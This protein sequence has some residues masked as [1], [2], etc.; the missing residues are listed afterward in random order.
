MLSLQLP[1]LKQLWQITDTAVIDAYRSHPAGPQ[2]S[3]STHTRTKS[4]AA[5]ITIII[6]AGRQTEIPRPI[7]TPLARRLGLF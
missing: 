1:L 7:N 5:S 6:T 2:A 3:L 4:V